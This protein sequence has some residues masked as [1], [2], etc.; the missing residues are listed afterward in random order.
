MSFFEGS[1]RAAGAAVVGAN[2]AYDVF[3]TRIL[4]PARMSR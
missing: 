4:D 2:L 3:R 1:R